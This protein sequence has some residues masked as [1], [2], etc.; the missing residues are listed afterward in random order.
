MHL[1][2]H[3]LKQML[4]WAVRRE[5]FYVE[6][7]LQEPA[8][9]NVRIHINLN[10]TFDPQN[11]IANR[12]VCLCTQAEKIRAEFD[13]NSHLDDP[14]QIERALIRGETR[15]TEHLH[16][17]PYIGEDIAPLGLSFSD[18]SVPLFLAAICIA[19]SRLQSLPKYGI[20]LLINSLSVF[21]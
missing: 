12:P 18:A 16:P 2:R 17:D 21:P 13:A 4:S 1:Y 8:C 3:S 6:V 14:N 9:F 7:G 20:T 19:V 5:V 10:E 11:T 15:L